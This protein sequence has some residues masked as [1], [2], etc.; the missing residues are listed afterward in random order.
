MK[1]LTIGEFA[2]ATRLSPKALRLSLHD[3]LP[4]DRYLISSDGLTSM[5]GS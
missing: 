4:G 5:P 3:A 2:R 1:L